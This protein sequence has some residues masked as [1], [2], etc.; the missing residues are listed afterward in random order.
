MQ[1]LYDLSVGGKLFVRYGVERFADTLRERVLVGEN[2]P[3][4][5]GNNRPLLSWGRR[6]KLWWVVAPTPPLNLIILCVD[7]NFF[8][9][10]MLLR[11]NPR[12]PRVFSALHR[13]SL[14]DSEKCEILTF[15]VIF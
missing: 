1:P 10:I 6:K 12:Q 9:C 3:S 5:S 4:G 13:Q 2:S 14:Q 7:K 15:N 11:K 8:K